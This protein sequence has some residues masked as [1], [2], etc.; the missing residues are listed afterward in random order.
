VITNG[1]LNGANLQTSIFGTVAIPGILT[2][3][4]L[5]DPEGPGPIALAIQ[6]GQLARGL[7]TPPAA[8]AASLARTQDTRR[9]R[10]FDLNLNKGLDQEVAPAGASAPSGTVKPTTTADLKADDTGNVRDIKKETSAATSKSTDVKKDRPRL[11]GGNSDS[12]VGDGRGVKKLRDGIHDGVQGFR[13]GVR[14][15]VKAATAR[16]GGDGGG[17]NTDDNKTE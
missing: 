4:T 9:V 14:H 8:E 10:T 17:A 12:R 16:G 5:L 13:D 2:D 1:V 7:L 3:T 15:V 11:L 6:L